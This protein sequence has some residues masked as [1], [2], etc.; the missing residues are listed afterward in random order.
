[1]GRPS[2]GSWVSYGLGTE[3]RDLPAFVVLPDPG[4]G[5]K[6]GPPAWGSGYLPATYQGTTM[7]PGARRFCDLRAAAGDQPRPAAGDARPGAAAQ[8]RASGASATATTSLRRASRPTNWPFACNRPRRSWSTSQDETAETLALYGI[9]PK[10]D[11]RVRPAA[12]C[13][14]GGWSSAAC[15]SCSFTRATPTAG[16]PTTTCCRQP[17]AVLPGAPTSRSPACS[18]TCDAAACWND[19]L[20]IWGG[21]F[22]RMPMSEQG[23]G[24]DHNPWGYTVWLA[25]GGVKRRL[26]LRRD[27]RR[28][29]A[30][31]REQG[32]RPRLARHDPAPA[33]P[34]PPRPHLLSQRPRRTADR[35]VG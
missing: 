19:T 6:G 17:H 5:I 7:R 30:G 11:R 21:E 3:N 14:P 34:R 18:A 4:G 35:P 13:W 10:G 9:G 27:R 16:T 24:R 25:G 32:P 2:V 23:K 28:R 29:P 8:S 31:R 15:A 22:G 33:G 20:V 1:M 12:A 26:R